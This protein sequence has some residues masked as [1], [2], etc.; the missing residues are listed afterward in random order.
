MKL[1]PR[2]SS[3]RQ[4]LLEIDKNA[5]FASRPGTRLCL[6]EPG[7][8]KWEPDSNAEEVA[9]LSLAV[10]AAANEGGVAEPAV[11]IIP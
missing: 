1:F 8:R 10:S 5:R 4:L 6:K 9:L 7:R 2:A 11:V 3:R